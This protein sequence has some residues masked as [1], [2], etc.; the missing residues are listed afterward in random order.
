MNE[1]TLQ[2]RVNNARFWPETK[3]ERVRKNNHWFD[4]LYN[5]CAVGHY[6]GVRLLPP[7]QPSRPDTP[8]DPAYLVCRFG[9]WRFAGRNY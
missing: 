2:H 4:A 5:A 7:L 6:A 3:W 1:R 8:C 9:E